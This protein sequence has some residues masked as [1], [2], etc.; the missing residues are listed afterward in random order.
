MNARHPY[1]ELPGEAERIALLHALQLLDTPAEPVFDRVTR[2]ASR[3]LGMPITAFSLVDSDRQFFKSRVGLDAQQTPR[4]VA[5][6]A[7]AIAQSEPLIVNDAHADP[8]FAAN[9]LVTG[10]PHVRFYAGV[11][12]RTDEGHAI[13]TLCAIDTQP[14]QLTPDDLATL[15]D[16]AAI[17]ADEVRRRE[18]LVAARGQLEHAG[19]AIRS[20]EDRLRAVFELASVGIALLD[21]NGGWI[22]VNAAAC[23]IVGYSDDELRRLGFQDIT[24]PDD[25]PADFTAMRN[26]LAGRIRHYASQKRF[27]RK[28]GS[29]VWVNVNASLKRDADGKP[30]YFIAGITDIH[31]QKTA[32]QQLA[33]MH[34]QLEERVGERTREL[35]DAN[36]HLTDAMA[37]ERQVEQALRAREAELSSIL[38]YANDAYIGIDTAGRVTA[39]NRLAE[40]TFG[41]SAFEAIGMPMEHLIVPPALRAKHERGLARYLATG[42]AT[43]LGRR[44]ELPAIRKD[45]SALTVEIR[46]HATEIDG[47]VT[48]SAFLHDITDRKQAE[49]QREHDIRHDT[50][51]GLL[52]RRALGELLPQA[53]ARSRR[54]N[55]GLALLFI[56]LDGFKA[57]NDRYGH[58]AGDEV[59]RHVAQRLRATVRQN[60]SVLRLAGDEFMVL[61]EGQP[62]TLDDARTV[63]Q[64]LVAELSRP[65]ELGAATVQI[66]ASIGIASQQPDD[67]VTPDE[68]VREADTRMYEAKQAGRGCVRPEA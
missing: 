10:A 47:E 37:R 4:D 19:A 58:D 8:R 46:I 34:A 65:M 15:Q 54:H 2:L 42:R 64:K 44:L 12:I 33:V 30:E 23:A 7:H 29:Q 38:E 3:L 50:L 21:P 60:D 62:C 61:L 57:V 59:L 16:L 68:L 25:L 13:G 39:W 17:V 67:T 55:I 6:C 1:P 32:E 20:S 63:A 48:F 18:Q 24:H 36:A 35:V 45:G 11:P 51:T 52:N 31:A 53:Q 5:F 40:R 9:A 56:D 22:A 66:G 41:W 28:D 26:L 49:E 43:V 14:R 27:I